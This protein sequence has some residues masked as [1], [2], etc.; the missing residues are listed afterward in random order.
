MKG[1]FSTLTDVMNVT[2]SKRTESIVMSIPP[3]LP[4]KAVLFS[5]KHSL[6]FT[7]PLIAPPKVA[8]LWMKSVLTKL[9]IPSQHQ[10][11]PPPYEISSLTYA[12]SL[13]G[14]A[15]LLMNALSTNVQLE[16]CLIAPAAI[17]AVLLMKSQLVI[18]RFSVW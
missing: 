13:F 17:F 15:E 10:S 14:F 4:L 2:S 18:T 5:T 1:E 6:A 11:A 3:P 8:L 9:V 7:A 16:W 12:G